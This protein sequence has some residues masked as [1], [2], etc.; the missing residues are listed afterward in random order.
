MIG[1]FE[2]E[3]TDTYKTFQRVS[4]Q[5]RDDCQFHALVG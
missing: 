3:N 5:L 4:S 2:D 1:Y